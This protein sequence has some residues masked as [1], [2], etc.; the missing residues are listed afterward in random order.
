[1]LSVGQP[2]KVRKLKPDGELHYS[3]DGL[4][5]GVVVDGLVLRAEFN[6]E[7]VEREWATFR[8]GDVF[9]EFYWFDRPYNVYQISAADGVLKGWYC[10]LSLPATLTGGD[11]GLELEY[12][13][14]ALD[15][16]ARPDGS[17]VVLDEDE[18]EDLL[19]QYPN[20]TA[21]AERGRA[22][23]LQLAHAGLLPRWPAAD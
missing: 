2:I 3:W 6:L 16:W 21:D 9:H 20:L 10:N 18:L 22:L 17:F 8:R 4:L 5:V 1:M 19:R 13:D 11:G 7:L 14:L 23:L 15:V 12:V